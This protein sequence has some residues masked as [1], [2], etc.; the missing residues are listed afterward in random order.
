MNPFILLTIAVTAFFGAWHS[1][2]PPSYNF[3][4]LL[5]PIPLATFTPTIHILTINTAN[6]SFTPVT[7]FTP[8]FS[9][10]DLLDSPSLSAGP[11]PQDLRTVSTLPATNQGIDDLQILGFGES[12]QVNEFSKIHYP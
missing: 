1:V 7:S 9:S 6:L 3:S 11:F 4:P 10:V 5:Q 2:I 12:T 8:Y